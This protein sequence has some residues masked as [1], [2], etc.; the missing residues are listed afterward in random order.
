MYQHKKQFSLLSGTKWSGVL[1]SEKA[2]DHHFTDFTWNANF[3]SSLLSDDAYY[4]KLST[5]IQYNL[6]ER[7]TPVARDLNDQM[8][9]AINKLLQLQYEDPG[10]LAQFED[11]MSKLIRLLFWELKECESVKKKMKEVD[12][13]NVNKAKK[14]IDYNLST[15]FTTPELSAKVGVNE[16]K[17]KKLFPQVAGYSVEEY[18]KYRLFCKAAKSIVQQRDESIKTFSAEAGY[19]S[20]STFTRAF[21]K[22]G[23]TPGELREDTWDLQKLERI[24][25]QKQND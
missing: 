23:C 11:L 4:N 8:T 5:Q 19:D 7:L 10:T 13:H 15:Q 14:L 16:H 3:L 6:P 21:K 9:N 25:S 22:M 2:G 1:T 24:I 17:L 20:V 18:R 12:W